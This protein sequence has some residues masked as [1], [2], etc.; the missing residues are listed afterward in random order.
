MKYRIPLA[1]FLSVLLVGAAIWY[2]FLNPQ[3]DEQAA[4]QQE[5][6]DLTAQEDQ[7]NT[8]LNMLV[9]LQGNQVKTRAT[10]GRIS[11]FLPD[12]PDQPGFLRTVQTLSDSAGVIVD[13]MNFGEPQAV[14]GSEATSGRQLSSMEVSFE[15]RGGYFNLV[16]FL[17]RVEF[18]FGRAFV[19]DQVSLNRNE[20]AEMNMSVN[21]IAYFY[22]PVSAETSAE[23]ETPIE[24][25]GEQAPPSDGQTA[26]PTETQA[27]PVE[28]EPIEAST[29][30]SDAG[31]TD[32]AA[33][34]REGGQ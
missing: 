18:Q 3:W 12:N 15:I 7:L 2:F 16:D 21:T 31:A 26:E 25:E 22:Q 34:S 10:L 32:A 24:S 11:A 28:D 9:E 33:T 30:S 29:P 5:I 27:T 20:T 13:G 4:T 14:E 6:Q 1:V 23:G 8:Q 17:R 19:V